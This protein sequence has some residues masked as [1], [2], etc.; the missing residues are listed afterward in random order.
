MQS[1]SDSPL[2]LYRALSTLEVE[3]AED[4]FGDDKPVVGRFHETVTSAIANHS[5]PMTQGAVCQLV[6][7]IIV[8]TKQLEASKVSSYTV[9]G[10]KDQSYHTF[11][12]SPLNPV[13][14]DVHQEA[15]HAT[16]VNQPVPVLPTHIE[17]DHQFFPK[18]FCNTCHG[19]PLPVWGE[20]RRGIF[21][22]TNKAH[23]KSC[24]HKH[25]H[26]VFEDKVRDEVHAIKKRKLDAAQDR[27]E[28]I[29]QHVMREYLETRHPC[30]SI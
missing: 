14:G 27:L 25:F 26:A 19:D 9:R 18:G 20:G 11:A 5:D 24:W 30:P 21:L 12:F 1:E 23:C 15:L 22:K 4:L 2:K 28:T 10:N 13:Y 8:D 6:L 3:H 29:P 7:M 17:K 16:L